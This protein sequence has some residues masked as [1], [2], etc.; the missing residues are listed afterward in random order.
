[1]KFYRLSPSRVMRI[2]RFPLR[3]EE[4][5][6]PNTVAM[7]QGV[8]GRKQPYEIWTMIQANKKGDIVRIISAWRYPGKT[9]PR[10]E[11]ALDFLKNEYFEF[12]SSE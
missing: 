12:K 9:K 2:I 8:Y 10:S 6:A 4:G 1:M 5:I 3:V 11:I 7:M